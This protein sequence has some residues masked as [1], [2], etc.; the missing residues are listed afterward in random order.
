ML[1]C[2]ICNWRAL[3][4]VQNG[5]AFLISFTASMKGCRNFRKTQCR[6]NSVT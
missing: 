2:M 3:S 6:G 4:D 1:M 5:I